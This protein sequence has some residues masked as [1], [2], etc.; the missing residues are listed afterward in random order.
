[1]GGDRAMMCPEQVW[2]ADDF[3]TLT[4]SWDLED[5]VELEEDGIVLT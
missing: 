1:M 3:E 5:D 4:M 2:E